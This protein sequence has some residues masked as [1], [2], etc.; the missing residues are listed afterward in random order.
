MK[1]FYFRAYKDIPVGQELLVWYGEE[2][3]QDLGIEDEAD[4][5]N[6]SMNQLWKGNSANHFREA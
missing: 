5:N 2:Y 4:T 1:I 6:E 3:A